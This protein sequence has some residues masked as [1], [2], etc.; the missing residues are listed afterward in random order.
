[1]RSENGSAK[2]IMHVI[3]TRPLAEASGL[4]KKGEEINVKPAAFADC[5]S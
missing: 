4:P 3:P 1:M 5:E 2:I